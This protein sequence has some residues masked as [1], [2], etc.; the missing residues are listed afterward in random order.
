MFGRGLN[1]STKELLFY[2]A[3]C[4]AMKHGVDVRQVNDGRSWWLAELLFR[5]MKIVPSEFI[6]YIHARKPVPDTTTTHV[7]L[8]ACFREW[9]EILQNDVTIN[10]A[11]RMDAL[12]DLKTHGHDVRNRVLV[13][14]TGAWLEKERLKLEPSQCREIEKLYERTRTDF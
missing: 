11:V 2:F 14:N 9:T 1:G 13:E 10:Q 8:L 12:T 6:Q 5:N 3:D 4:V 7:V